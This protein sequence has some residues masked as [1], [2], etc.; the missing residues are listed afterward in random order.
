[1]F[2]KLYYYN[3]GVCDTDIYPSYT[4]AEEDALA[5]SKSYTDSS[6]YV[7]VTLCTKHYEHLLMTINGN[8]IT[9]NKAFHDKVTS[10]E[11][12]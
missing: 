8:G 10:K 7:Q 11:L 4:K 6:E 5:I 1:M 2:Y 9:H 3:N 12:L